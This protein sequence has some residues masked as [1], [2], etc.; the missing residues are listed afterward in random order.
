MRRN[1][2]DMYRRAVEALY[3]AEGVR[4]DANETAVF[5]RQLEDIDAE[6]HRV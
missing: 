3:S 4:T 6:L 1:R 2:F 5:A